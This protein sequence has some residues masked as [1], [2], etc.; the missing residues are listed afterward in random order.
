MTTI[1]IPGDSGVYVAPFEDK[2]VK[3]TAAQV[4]VPSALA[5][6]S[7]SLT[8]LGGVM[9]A[10]GSFLG[11]PLG[12]AGILTAFAAAKVLSKMR[13][14]GLVAGL[15]TLGLISITGA[16]CWL[17]AIL[18]PF[19]VIAGALSIFVSG[20]VTSLSATFLP[21]AL[22]VIVTGAPALFAM[23]SA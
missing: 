19:A 8:L 3:P 14:D 1:Y 10:G 15:V 17:L 5:F 22:F 23:K 18:M 20:G 7:I 4:L 21:L 9:A 2:L 11:A 6:G 16:I 13:H 12:V